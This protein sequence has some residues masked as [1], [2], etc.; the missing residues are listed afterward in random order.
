M[1]AT[2]LLM[3]QA[4]LGGWIQMTTY[5]IYEHR[6]NGAYI[7]DKEFSS[8]KQARQAIKQEQHNSHVS[9]GIVDTN[10]KQ[11]IEHLLKQYYER[12]ENKWLKV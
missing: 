3:R 1:I 9:Y 12:V 11:E 4:K 7:Y 6:L 2:L 5:K 10:N 8:I